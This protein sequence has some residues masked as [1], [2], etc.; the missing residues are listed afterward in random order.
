MLNVIELPQLHDIFLMLHA[1]LKESDIPHHMTFK[2]CVEEVLLDHMDQL[3]DDMVVFHPFHLIV[4][5]TH[6]IVS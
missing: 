1:E 5:L 3:Q 2:K 6:I 4:A